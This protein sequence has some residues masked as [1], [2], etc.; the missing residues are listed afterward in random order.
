MSEHGAIASP[1]PWVRRGLQWLAAGAD[2]LDFAAGH[3]RHARLAESMGLRAT[4][5]DRDGV[6][7]ASVPAAI[8]S[9]T[10]DLEAEPWPFAPASFD[11]IV[12]CN[13]LY[14][15]RFWELCALLR[16]SGLLIYET[17]A[18][19]NERYGRPSNPDF[20]L[21]PGELIDL[22]RAEGLHI[23]GFED[24]FAGSGRQARIERVLAVGKGAD[25]EAFAIE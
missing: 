24:G 1:S 7:L 22:C 9:I 18:Q 12:V 17:F 4:A 13:Y 20:L 14:R 23:I 15:P 25:L 19:G 6:A 10:T 5:V 11:A 2:V 8:R 3:G 16:P 21:A